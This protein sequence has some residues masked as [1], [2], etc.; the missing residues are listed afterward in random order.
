MTNPSTSSEANL[1]EI[2]RR[3]RQ[4]EIDHQIQLQ[5][6]SRTRAEKILSLFIAYYPYVF[7]GFLALSVIVTGMM[8]SI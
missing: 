4:A 5:S 2:R 3:L 6:Q 1:D 8:A 7:I